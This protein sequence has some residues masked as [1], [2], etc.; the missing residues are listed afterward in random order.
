[1]IATILPSSTTWHAVNYNEKKVSMGD[2]RLLEIKNFGS[3][4]YT[5]YES[6]DQLI[7]YLQ[8]YSSRNSRIKKPQ[9]HLAISCKG[10]EMSYDE[11]LNFAHDYLKEMGYGDPEQP[12]LIYAHHDTN[13]NHIHIITSRVAP[14][15]IKIDHNHEERR[16]QKVIEKLLKKNVKETA[17]RDVDEA[18]KYDFNTRGQFMSII[19]ALNYECFEKQG[20]IYVKKGGMILMSL[21]SAEIDK[22]IQEKDR[23][24]E[25]I[26]DKKLYAILSK[27]RDL[28]SDKKSL[29]D[30][31]RKNFGISIDFIGRK[32]NP[33]GYNIVDFN[34]K[35]VIS[36]SN[37]MSIKKLLN[38]TTSEEKEQIIDSFIDKCFDESPYISTFEINNR[39]RRMGI[40]IR[41]NEIVSKINRRP[42]KDFMADALS[43][44][45]K[46]K[47]AKEFKPQTKAEVD[48]ILRISK[49]DSSLINDE[50]FK[51]NFPISDTPSYDDEKMQNIETL[52][53]E[54]IKDN[55]NVEMITDEWK[56][57]KQDDKY[58][59][60]NFDR[61]E[62]FDLDH[63]PLTDNCKDYLTNISKLEWICSFNP[64]T[65]EEMDA[66]AHFV[67][68][69]NR[70]VP[71]IVVNDD[72]EYDPVDVEEL[73]EMFTSNDF[74]ERNKKLDDA[75]WRVFKHEGKLYAVNLDKKSIV[76]LKKAKIINPKENIERGAGFNISHNITALLK[77]NGVGHGANREW[78]VGNNRYNPDDPDNKNSMKY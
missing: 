16:S 33:Y 19:H 7:E 29:T 50:K 54:S 34:N 30:E 17:K 3:I 15:G 46:I 5:G 56:V 23:K 11:L 13:N 10:N 49:F 20:K 77:D 62:V 57:I 70:F 27:Y 65:Q 52:V 24:N 35:K 26:F 68:L 6:P 39:L 1:M 8:D 40:Y 14:N 47:W 45:N 67:K 74:E 25:K 63:T 48:F 43:R 72:V 55:F 66:L 73:K 4:D 18:M 32:D 51:S 41:K 2:A 38:F 28:C 21:D 71:S 58:L 75:G 22:C 64:H 9:F 61:K 69:D 59:L 60:V 36:G 78:E 76:D 31:L 53:S 42:L 37:V 44:N 12:L